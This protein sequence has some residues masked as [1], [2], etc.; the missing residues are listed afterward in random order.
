MLNE[1]QL[2][3]ACMAGV[4]TAQY[5]LYERYS[6]KMYALSLRYIKDK[7]EAKDVLQ[8]AFIKVYENIGK[9]RFDCPL[10]AWIRRILINTALRAIQNKKEFQDIDELDFATQDFSYSEN[11]S[12]SYL[13]YEQLMA[14]VHSLP[15]GCK[16]I[17]SLYAIDGYKHQ[18]IAE[19]LG[20]NEGTSKSQYA[21]AKKLLI[22]KIEIENNRFSK[23]IS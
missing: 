13:D 6:G 12:L 7:D 18:E 1:K 23:T 20:I 21:R 2:V 8:N 3:E 4:R 17:F 11:M 5:Q 9:F 22:R 16:T 14:L 10:E 15:D 19:L